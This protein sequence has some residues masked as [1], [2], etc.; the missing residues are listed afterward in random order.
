MRNSVVIT[1]GVIGLVG[2]LITTAMLWQFGALVAL[3]AAPFGAS[4]LVAVFSL[5][6][7][8]RDRG[9]K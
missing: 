4:L 7:G 8:S 5:I 2:G 6:L 1:Y 9:S 3:V